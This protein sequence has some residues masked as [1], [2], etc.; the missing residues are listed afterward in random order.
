M[1]GETGAAQP[2]PV[3]GWLQSMVAQAEKVPNKGDSLADKRKQQS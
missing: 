1:K 2:H 3:P